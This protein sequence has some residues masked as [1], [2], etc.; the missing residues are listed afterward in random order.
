M[1]VLTAELYGG[2]NQTMSR[3]LD[4]G[5]LGALRAVYV[6]LWLKPLLERPVL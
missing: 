5:L 2:L 3:F 6:I 4:L 1:L